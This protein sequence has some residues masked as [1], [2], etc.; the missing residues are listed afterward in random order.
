[1]KVD[2]ILKGEPT[3][4]KIRHVPI[5]ILMTVQP[6]SLNHPLEAQGSLS[7]ASSTSVMAGLSLTSSILRALPTQASAS[8]LNRKDGVV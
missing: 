1:M 6:A 2:T 4:V 7:E 5:A 3:T 8:F